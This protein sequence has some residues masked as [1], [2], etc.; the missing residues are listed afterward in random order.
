MCDDVYLNDECV[1]LRKE[2]NKVR[3]EKDELKTVLTL[4]KGFIRS[5]HKDAETTVLMLYI[6]YWETHESLTLGEVEKIF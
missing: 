5:N 1:R 2:L 6:N 3:E 4:I